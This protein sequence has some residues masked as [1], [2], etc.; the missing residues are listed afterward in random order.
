MY[1]YAGMGKSHPTRPSSNPGCVVGYEGAMSTA[2][3]FEID[4][5]RLKSGVDRRTTCMIRN[6]PNKYTQQMLIDMI[7]E[8]N[9]ATYDFV[10]LRMDFKNRC[11]VGYAFI[12]FVDPLDILPFATRHM[13]RHWP[14][15]NSEKI[16]RLTYARIQGKAALLEKFRHSRIM[17]EPPSYRPRVFYSEEERR[18]EEE[19]FP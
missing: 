13:G 15:F 6:I 16:C 11:N 19:P 8:S 9:W 14:R 10:Y 4:F 5:W 3:D 12:N 7:N 1:G 2:V 17:S 18:G